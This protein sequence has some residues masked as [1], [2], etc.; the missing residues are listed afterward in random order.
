MVFVT[1]RTVKAGTHSFAI[2]GD[3][4]NTTS[5]LFYSVEISQFTPGK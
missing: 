1:K 4:T 2:T 3:A 5:W